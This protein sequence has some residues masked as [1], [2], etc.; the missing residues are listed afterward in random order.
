M[1]FPVNRMRRLRRSETLRRMTR[2]TVLRREDLILPLFVVEG[3]G[4]REPVA[5]MPGVLRFSV[6][7]AV[8]EGQAG[9]RPGRAGRD[10]LWRSGRAGEGRPGQWRRFAGRD[11][12]ARGRG[13]EA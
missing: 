8:G 6:D 1:S 4:V 5:S 7:Q 11:R 9:L 13:A 12:A 10:P 3:S 2:E